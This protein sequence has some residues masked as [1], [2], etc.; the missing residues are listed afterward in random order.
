VNND[1]RFEVTPQHL[2]LLRRMNVQWTPGT[3]DVAQFDTRLVT[4]ADVLRKQCGYSGQHSNCRD[5]PHPHREHGAPLSAHIILPELLKNRHFTNYFPR[6][7][8]SVWPPIVVSAGVDGVSLPLLRCDRQ[9]YY[10]LTKGIWDDNCS[11][12]M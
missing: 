10:G 12:T 11:S 8:I 4:S 3:G 6:T 5:I 7:L 2:K 1:R 9:P